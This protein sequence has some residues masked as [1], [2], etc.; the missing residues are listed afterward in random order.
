MQ[1]YDMAE[2][3]RITIDG[4]EWQGL[5]NFGE[6]SLEKDQIEVPEFKHIRKIQSGIT[7]I[8]AID[9]TFKISRNSKTFQ[10]I[11]SWY[12]N[13]EIHDIVKIRTDA[14]GTESSRTLLTACECVR[15]YEPPFDGAA[16]TYAQV[17]TRFL[18]WDIIPI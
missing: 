15:Y 4:E 7:R 10:M 11:K 12:F 16:P 14:S 6:I 1:S 8:P 18:P 9:V 17:Q 5:V 3:V 13:D 2:K